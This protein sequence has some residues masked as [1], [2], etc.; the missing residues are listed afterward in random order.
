MD[1]PG[2]YRVKRDPHS[3]SFIM[4]QEF[5]SV[6][7]WTF[8]KKDVIYRK[9]ILIDEGRIQGVEVDVCYAMIHHHHHWHNSPIW[10]KAFFRSFCQLSLFLAAF[11]QFLSPKFLASSVL[12]SL[13]RFIDRRVSDSPA[14]ASLDFVTMLFPE[15][16]VSRTS[17]PQQS[18]RTYWFAS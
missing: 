15:Q 18:W 17:N 9:P 5:L 3:F 11:L 6:D 8:R 1:P 12:K 14:I 4:K 10:A 2:S 16:A 7:T 13:N